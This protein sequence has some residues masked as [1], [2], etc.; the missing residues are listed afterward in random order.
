[1]LR[2]L[3]ILPLLFLVNP[4]NS[5]IVIN[6]YS[7]SNSKVVQ[8]E[9]GDFPDWIELYNP[10][11]IDVHLGGFHLSDNAT[12]LF[13]WTFPDITLNQKS[14]MLVFASGKDRSLPPLSYRTII[15]IG[16]TWNYLIPT[17]DIG[18]S[19]RNIGYDASGWSSGPSGFGY[20]DNDDATVLN[21]FIISVFVRKEFEVSNLNDVA[22]FVLS[23]D[24]DDSFVAFINGKEIA[25]NN[26]G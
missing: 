13:K 17:S 9:D 25:R 12:S 8:D 10:T 16:S 11:D 7:S 3:L 2:Y 5:Q 21:S 26:L 20:G 14:Y 1:M 15:D 4:L 6:E 19:W 23:I 22:D 24:Y 18:T